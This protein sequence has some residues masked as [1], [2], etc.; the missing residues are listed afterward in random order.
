MTIFFNF[1]LEFGQ[2]WFEVP[3]VVEAAKLGWGTCI[4]GGG[5]VGEISVESEFGFNTK[6]WWLGTTKSTDFLF[7]GALALVAFKSILTYA[8]AFLFLFSKVSD[9]SGM[10]TNQVLLIFLKF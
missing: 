7:S 2:T 10:I 9:C 4:K 5:G 6:D 1:K 8:M 3:F